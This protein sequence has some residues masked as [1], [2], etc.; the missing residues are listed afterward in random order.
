MTQI[1]VAQLLFATTHAVQ[2]ARIWLKFYILL[3]SGNININFTRKN[4]NIPRPSHVLKFIAM[5]SPKKAPAK[6]SAK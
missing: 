6:C 1:L 2:L 5:M 4:A 3:I